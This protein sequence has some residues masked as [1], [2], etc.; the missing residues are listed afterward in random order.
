MRFMTRSCRLGSAMPARMRHTASSGTTPA[1]DIGWPASGDAPSWSRR[2]SVW[3][4]SA[5]PCSPASPETTGSTTSY[6]C[7]PKTLLARAVHQGSELGETIT[8][9][10]GDRGPLLSGGFGRLLGEDRFQQGHD[11]RTLLRLHA[12]QRIAHPMHPT[13]LMRGMED[14]CGSGPEPLVVVGDHELHAPQAPVRQGAQER[15]P[16][17]F[18]FRRAGGHAQHLAPPIRVHADSDYHSDR[19]DPARLTRLQVSRVN[20]EIRPGALDG[21]GEKGVHA[22]VNLR[23]QPRDLAFGDAGCAHG[24]DEVVHGAGRDPMDIGLLD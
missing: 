16:E 4:T 2:P 17:G 5:S 7:S 1:S 10:I 3:W 13:A 6:L 21:P 9:G 14:L 12:R 15:R 24:F 20:P 11:R 19:D 23:A 22:L 8:Q 18:G